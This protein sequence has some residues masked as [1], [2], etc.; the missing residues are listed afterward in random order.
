MEIKRKIKMLLLLLKSTFTS[1][2]SNVHES[3]ESIGYD[4][5]IVRL[6][7]MLIVQLA[8]NKMNE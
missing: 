4:C 5:L 1:T 2:V 6:L 7:S 3:K 8:T